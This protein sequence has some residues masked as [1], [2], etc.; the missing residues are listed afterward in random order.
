MYVCV[1]VCHKPLWKLATAAVI[2]WTQMFLTFLLFSQ[3]GISRK[4]ATLWRAPHFASLSRTHY[5]S[6]LLVSKHRFSSLKYRS[7]KI[8]VWIASFCQNC[9]VA[10]VARCFILAAKK[11]EREE[12]L[13]YFSMCCMCWPLTTKCS[14][15]CIRMPACG[16]IFNELSCQNR[17]QVFQ[18]FKFFSSVFY[19]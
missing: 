11:K 19:K 17:H 12:K 5:C 16:A 1:C 8:Y 15:G 13:S 6:L 14:S 3:N 4:L 7:K 2:I 10:F 18:V 9:H